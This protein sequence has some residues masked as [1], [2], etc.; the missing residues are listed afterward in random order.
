MKTTWKTSLKENMK[1]IKLI[2]ETQEHDRNKCRCEGCK[3][4]NIFGTIIHNGMMYHVEKDW[5]GISPDEWIVS[6][7]R[8][9]NYRND[10]K[11]TFE[12]MKVELIKKGVPLKE[13][14]EVTNKLI[15][16]MIPHVVFAK[17]PPQGILREI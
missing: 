13:I 9:M 2:R 6:F 17:S 15:M 16:D 3:W 10:K 4:Y 8:F 11:I 1:R 7:T 5:D 12:K 14:D